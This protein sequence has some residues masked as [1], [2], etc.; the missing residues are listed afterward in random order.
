MGHCEQ[1]ALSFELAGV[2]EDALALELDRLACERSNRP[3]LP[4]ANH[5]VVSITGGVPAGCEID[6]GEEGAGVEAGAQFPPGC[7]DSVSYRADPSLS[8]PLFPADWFA[9]DF[10]PLVLDIAKH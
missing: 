1:S 9:T 6:C 4:K 2:S 3:A 7:P 8:V 5:L 10:G